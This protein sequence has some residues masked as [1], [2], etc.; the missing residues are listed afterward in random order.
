[1]RRV[2]RR[3]Q[4]EH[5]V[6]QT[7]KRAPSWVRVVVIGVVLL[8]LVGVAPAAYAL[9]TDTQPLAADPSP[10]P[11]PIEPSGTSTSITNITL[12]TVAIGGLVGAMTPLVLGLVKILRKGS[13][14][15]D[16]AEARARQDAVVLALAAALTKAQEGNYTGHER[17][18]RDT[19]PPHGDERR[20]HDQ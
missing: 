11:L 19:G 7:W 20:G 5:S 10:A 15:D 14:T 9:V 3:K 17:R 2:G 18:A 1:M 12:L 13:G 6:T 16:E 8:V 4:E